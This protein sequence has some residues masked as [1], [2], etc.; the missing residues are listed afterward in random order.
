MVRQ[1]E[2]GLRVM[3]A[4]R[5]VRTCLAL[6]I[7]S[8]LRVC[9]DLPVEAEDLIKAGKRSDVLETCFVQNAMF[10]PNDAGPTVVRYFVGDRFP[11]VWLNNYTPNADV[12]KK[13]AK[14]LETA[15]EDHYGKELSEEEK[16]V[17]VKEVTDTCFS[18][19][20]REFYRTQH[21]VG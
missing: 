2:D 6:L 19:L 3:A 10:S 12:S 13:L 14:K 16:K 1:V 8:N 15:W 17:A 4:R 11:V 5:L 20:D 21:L 9:I 7:V 18:V